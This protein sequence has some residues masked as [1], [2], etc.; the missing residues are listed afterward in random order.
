VELKQ[1]FRQSNQ[2]FVSLLNEIRLGEC[3]SKSLEILGKCKV[4]KDQ[5]VQKPLDG[6]LPTVL[7]L[8]LEIME[9]SIY[10]GSYNVAIESPILSSTRSLL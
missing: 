3:S 10:I 6:I 8:V 2:E 1:I 7:Y 9:D 4:S 5:D